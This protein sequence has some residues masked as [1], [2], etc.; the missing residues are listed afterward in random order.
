MFRRNLLEKLALI[1]LFCS[2]TLA[3]QVTQIVK[4][5]VID[6]QTRIGLAGANVM[7]Q[8]TMLG[9]STDVDG[10][11][12]ILNV[13]VGRHTIEVMFIGY[14]SITIPEI[15]VGSGKE[16]V[17][18]IELVE[19]II[20]TET[21]VVTPTIEKSKALNNTASVSARSFSVEET[22]RYAGGFDDPARLASSFAGVTYGNAQDNAVIIR[23]NAPKGL[24]WRLEGI[25]I[26]NPNHFPDGNVFGGGLFTVF[27]SQLLANSDFFTGAFPAEYGNALS[28]VFDMKLRNGNNEVREWTFQTGLMGID[29]ATEGPFNSESRS[30]YLVNYRY[31]TIGLL[32][33]LNVIDTEQK[34]N[35]QDLSFKLNFPGKK[36]GTFSLW[37]LGSI[38]HNNEV[39]GT[40]ST[41]WEE[42]WDRVKYDA[43]FRMGTIG[44][45]HRYILGK[46]TFINT[47][48]AT[49][50]ED[51]A[52]DLDRLD[53]TVTL[54]K[55][56]SIHSF[57][58]K[59]TI[60]STVD[61]KFSQHLFMMTGFSWNH[62]SYDMKL[63]STIDD[64]PETFQTFVDEKGTSQLF[65]A[66]A[67]WQINLNNKLRINAGLHYEYFML[68]N[69]S[70]IE[71]RLGINWE[72]H[73]RHILSFGYGIHSQL[74]NI[75][76]YL[77][78]R[79]TENGIIMP[80][81]DLVFT[82]A[83]HFVI[84]YDYQISNNTRLKVE[85]YY[86]YLYDVPV[87]E[88][89]TFSF[90][91]LKDERY[92]NETL[93]NTGKGENI[94]VDLTLERFLSDNYY[95]LITA[96]IFDSKYK[97]GDGIERNSRYNRNFVFNALFGKEYIISD[98]NILSINGRFTYMGGERTSPVL[99]DASLAAKRVVYDDTQAFKNTL[100]DSKYL[101]VTASYRIN[102]NNLAHIFTLQIKNL[103]GSPNDNGYVYNFKNDDLKEDKQVIVLPSISYKIEF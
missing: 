85:P 84:G 6:E 78:R 69:N 60:K 7:V 30:S 61:Q 87:T 93:L 21:I 10:Y 76:Y 79:E 48:I 72:L 8:G 53:D 23:G 97:G 4:G 11:F 1:I 59:T 83:N 89:G 27:S 12:R 80:N 38:D 68:N 15:L 39:E 99:R 14:K 33:D 28:G 86:Q 102:N 3:S 91:N 42:D 90:I 43:T 25:E 41:K 32:T 34:P 58:G 95:Y 96:S 52:Y 56:E 19:E 9:A 16:I 20:Q 45:N 46:S 73:P 82:R 101:D 62:L 40:D 44:L 29:F 49:T 5:Q 65:Q 50:A 55:N 67:H 22:Q 66:F 98:H 64:E 18:N 57:N 54:R 17:L 26:P 71:P 36:A 63:K 35:Y 24:L 94:G 100:S 92:F 74:E 13:P 37:G 47:T 75:R 103:L 2:T 51:I 77:S 70:S 88:G 31:S 81:K